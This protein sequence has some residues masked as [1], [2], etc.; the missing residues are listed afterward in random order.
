MNTPGFLAVSVGNL[1][2]DQ[3]LPDSYLTCPK[4]RPLLQIQSECLLTY[5]L[6]TCHLYL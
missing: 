6:M 4:E 5:A 3:L 2:V 1:L